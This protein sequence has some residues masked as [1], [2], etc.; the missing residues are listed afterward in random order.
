MIRNLYLIHHTHTDIGYTDYQ[1]K[2]LRKHVNI[3]RDLRNVVTDD[4]KWNCE[5]LFAVERFLEEA[6][7]EEKEEF[8][9]LVEKKRIGI[10]GTYYNFS[11]SVDIPHLTRRVNETLEVFRKRGIKVDSAMIADVNGISLGNL[12]SYLDTGVEF[13]FTNI[14]CHHGQYPLYGVSKPYFWKSMKTG[15]RMLV[16]NGEHYNC[17]NAWGL[18][19]PKRSNMENDPDFEKKEFS[20]AL[21]TSIRS[22]RDY[23]SELYSENYKYSFIISAISG[24]FNDNAP[25][26]TK[27]GDIVKAINERMK[28][29]LE[30]RMVTL[31]EL[32]E[33]IKDECADA[34]E[35]TGDLNDWWSYGVGSSPYATKHYLE[36][37]RK[38]RSAELFAEKEEDLSKDLTRRYEDGMLLYAEHTFGYSSSI[39]NPSDTMCSNLDIRK[40]SYASLANENANLNMLRIYEKYGESYKC[41]DREGDITVVHK[42]ED[43]LVAVEFNLDVGLF[44]NVEVVCKE[45]GEVMDS[46]VK[47]PPRGTDIAF[48]DYFRKGEVKHYHYKELPPVKR[49]INTKH[50]YTGSEGI[51]DIE[52]SYE[53]E[54]ARMNYSLT[55]PFFSVSYKVGDRITSVFDK[56]E[57]RELLESG[58][59]TLLNPVYQRSKVRHPEERHDLGRNIRSQHA[60]TFQ[61]K[62]VGIRNK[63][64]GSVFNSVTLDMEMEGAEKLSLTLKAYHRI[65]RLDVTFELFKTLSS[66]IESVFL[67]LS[68]AGMKSLYFNKGGAYFRPGVEQIPGSCMEYYLLTDGLVYDSG[69]ARYRVALLD[70]PLVYQGS[71][72]HHLIRLCDNREENNL[73]PLYSWI[74]NNN[75][76]TNFRLALSGISEFR[77]SIVKEEADV[78]KSF[79]NLSYDGLETIV[80]MEN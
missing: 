21:E 4:F 59:F 38:Q 18:T 53:G 68:L 44:Y 24:V 50:A 31:S 17:A 56:E 12:D 11:D 43:K 10:S 15:R 36:A 6:T 23:I 48:Y 75:W 78:K 26:N 25:P 70:A 32:Y 20:T 72:D 51:R 35:Y 22:I 34:P 54:E 8:F 58:E 30:V 39:Y 7:D 62:I 2:I 14:H 16:W 29:E 60:E 74:M 67:P 80:V 61:A 66:D 71:M 47:I 64:I 1:E 13:L 52:S 42:G 41:Y 76:E 45:T 79:E 5:T 9:S 57:G 27:I 3:I 73:R 40:T 49:H 63:V 28:G 77:Y 65:K 55:S 69:S 37:V 33:L 46:Q 19:Y